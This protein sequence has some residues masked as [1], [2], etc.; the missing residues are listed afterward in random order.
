MK[1]LNFL[2]IVFFLFS[3]YICQ[4]EKNTNNQVEDTSI[5]LAELEEKLGKT[6]SKLK[7]SPEEIQKKKRRK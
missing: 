4:K 1:Y 3:L 5:K 6:Q 7:D 2:V